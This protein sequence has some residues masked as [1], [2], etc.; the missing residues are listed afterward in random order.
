ML[1]ASGMVAQ[2]GAGLQRG[3]DDAHPTAARAED[4]LAAA[5]QHIG[6]GQ[7]GQHLGGAVEGGDA[8]VAIDGDHALGERIEDDLGDRRGHG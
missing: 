3:G 4:L 8:A 6:A 2:G 1:D 5:P 7:A